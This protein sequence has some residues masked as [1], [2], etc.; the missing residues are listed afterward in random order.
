M[1]RIFIC[2]I[3]VDLNKVLKVV[4]F[5]RDKVMDEVYIE[6]RRDILIYIGYCVIK[7][8]MD[9]IYFCVECV[10]EKLVNFV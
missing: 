1:Y 3:I 7:N 8:V 4:R 2:F 9:V 5:E 6:R 10:Y